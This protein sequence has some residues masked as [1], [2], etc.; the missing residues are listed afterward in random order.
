MPVRETPTTEMSGK[1]RLRRQ[2]GKPRLLSTSSCLSPQTQLKDRDRD[3]LLGP[4]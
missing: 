2:S 3:K 4:H 1:P